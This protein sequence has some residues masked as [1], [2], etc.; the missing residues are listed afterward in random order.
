MLDIPAEAGNFD[1]V[2]V[3]R[4]ARKL[5]AVHR[6]VA[7]VRG[8]AQGEHDVVHPLLVLQTPNTPDPTTSGS[9][10]TR[11]ATSSR[12]CAASRAP[13]ARRALRPEVRQLG[14]STGS[15]RRRVQDETTCACADRQGRHLHRL[16]L[17][18]RRGDGVVPAGQGPHPHH[19]AA[20]P[21]GAQPARAPR[22]RRRASSTRSTASC[23]SSTERPPARWSSS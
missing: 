10:S 2:L 17:P 13:R 11:S 23:P 21:D 16:G 6:A 7:G 1:S 3:R 5:G 20:R 19:P 22:A 14:R 15:S 8:H 12:T 9:R 18:A 4:A